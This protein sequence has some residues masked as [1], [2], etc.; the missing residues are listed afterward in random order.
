MPSSLSPKTASATSI[1][2]AVLNSLTNVMGTQGA[3]PLQVR[4]GPRDF[5]HT[6]VCPGGERQAGHGPFENPGR[7]FIQGA[8]AP[9]LSGPHLAVR[10]Y[11]CSTPK[12]S[13]LPL[14][15]SGNAG[16]DG[17]ARLGGADR[18]QVFDWHGGHLD[19]EIDAVQQG[20]GDPRPIP[21]HVSRIARAPVAFRTVHPTRAPVRTTIAPISSA[22]TRSFEA[23]SPSHLDMD[24]P[25]IP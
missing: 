9:D 21:G 3:G 11:V 4:D 5:E 2:Q 14:P 24:S 15:S 12:T 18:S 1:Q 8:P 25:T 7:L 13:M 6:I 10:P 23:P 19:M 22:Y 20:A 17:V 16:A